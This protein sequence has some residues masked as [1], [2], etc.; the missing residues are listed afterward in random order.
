MYNSKKA[1]HPIINPAE[2]EKGS[3]LTDLDIHLSR[4]EINFSVIRVNKF[5]RDSQ[6]Q[7]LKGLNQHLIMIMMLNCWEKIK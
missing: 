7:D 4:W 1:H 6:M 2:C 5:R 3:V